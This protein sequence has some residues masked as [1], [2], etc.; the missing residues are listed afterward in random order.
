MS[1]LMK[2]P[3]CRAVHYFFP[4]E[5]FPRVPCHI[6]YAVDVD[7]ALGNTFSKDKDP[8]AEGCYGDVLN[9]KFFGLPAKNDQN[10]SIRK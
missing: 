5:D 9:R 4:L 8:L 6:S 2:F 3:F 1:N 10:F 7:N